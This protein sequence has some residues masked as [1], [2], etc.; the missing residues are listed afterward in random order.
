MGVNVDTPRRSDASSPAIE[1]GELASDG[2]KPALS[3]LA[4]YEELFPFVWRVARRRGVPEAALDDVCQD[5]F[6]IVHKRLAEFEGRSSLK[7]WVYG[8]LN[9]VVLM[10]HRTATRRDPNRADIDP[11]LLVDST[12]RPDEAASGAEAARIAHDLL[13][14]LGDDKRAVFILVELEGMS[15]PEAAEAVQTNLNTAYAR[16]RSAR[17]EFAAAVARFQARERRRT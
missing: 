9:N 3:F 17:A 5:V 12:T 15:V 14:Q 2:S 7:T 6:V 1:D 16:L 10:R 11:E 4:V 13:A 8:I